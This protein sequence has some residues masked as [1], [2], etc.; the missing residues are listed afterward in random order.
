VGD[1]E[2]GQSRRVEEEQSEKVKEGQ[3]GRVEWGRGGGNQQV[4]NIF[5]SLTCGGTVFFVYLHF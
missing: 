3:S 5:N 4:L 2:E 1:V